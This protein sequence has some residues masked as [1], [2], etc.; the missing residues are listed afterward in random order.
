MVRECLHLYADEPPNYCRFER[1]PADH[2]AWRE[3]MVS[4]FHIAG[5]RGPRLRFV[6]PTRAK[7]DSNTGPRVTQDGLHFHMGRYRRKG[8]L[9]PP[10]QG[11]AYHPPAALLH[12]LSDILV[13]RALVAMALPQDPHMALHAL[14]VRP[15]E[16]SIWCRTSAEARRGSRKT[17]RRSG[18]G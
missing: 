4:L 5:T 6:H 12:I 13:N 16:W 14:A 3:A 2:P 18:P 1:G 10:T 17:K 8:D 15:E 7:Q 11:V 9:I